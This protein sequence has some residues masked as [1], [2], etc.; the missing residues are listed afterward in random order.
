MIPIRSIPTFSGPAAKHMA[1]LKLRSEENRLRIE[2]LE[3][4]RMREDIE[5]GTLGG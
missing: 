1:E 2:R 5:A 4:E 3:L